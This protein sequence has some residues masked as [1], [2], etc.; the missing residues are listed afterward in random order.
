MKF[1]ERLKRERVAQQLTQREMAAQLNVSRQT[2]SSWETGNSYP[3]I[4]R[5]IQ[6]SDVYQ[7]SL[8]VLL[9]EDSG[10]K[11]YLKKQEVMDE[12][13][14][15]VKL[16]TVI[17]LIFIAILLVIPVH[18]IAG[19]LVMLMGLLNIAVLQRIQRFQ[20]AVTGERWVNRWSTRR[21]WLMLTTGVLLVV[22]LGV[23][24]IT[25]WQ[26]TSWVTKLVMAAGVTL[27][28]LV[29]LEITYR[30]DVKRHTEEK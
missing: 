12:I 10:M 3:D 19:G 13:K 23:A 16:T 18:G 27:A 30:V 6:L 20:E 9:K 28:A 15:I 21:L 5:L 1:G 26:W 11:E 24:G 25:G 7:I 14:P 17:D 2:I 8:D 4:D 29:V 22:A